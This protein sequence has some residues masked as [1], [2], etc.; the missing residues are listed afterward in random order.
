M[1]VKFDNSR[2]PDSYEVI[3][4]KISKTNEE[5]FSPIQ[6]PSQLVSDQKRLRHL[7]CIH[8]RNLSASTKIFKIDDKK[9]RSAGVA[10]SNLKYVS[11]NIFDSRNAGSNNTQ[12]LCLKCFFTLQEPVDKFTRSNTLF[13]TN[14]SNWRFPKRRLAVKQKI[15]SLDAQTFYISELQDFCSNALWKPIDF[16]KISDDILMRTSRF[17]LR[18]W[19]LNVAKDDKDSSWSTIMKRYADGNPTLILQWDVDLRGL[20]YAGDTLLDSL[21]QLQAQDENNGT[22]KRNE[23][24]V[25]NVFFELDKYHRTAFFTDKNLFKKYKYSSKS[26]GSLLSSAESSEHLNERDSSLNLKNSK[27]RVPYLAYTSPNSIRKSYDRSQIAQFH[28]LQKYLNKIES[29]LLVFRNFSTLETVV[30]SE[31][32]IKSLT[33]SLKENS[34]ADVVCS[35]DLLLKKK[36]LEQRIKW[37][38][39]EIDEETRILTGKLEK[40]RSEKQLRLELLRQRRNLVNTN[41]FSSMTNSKISEINSK[42][43]KRD[44]FLKKFEDQAEKALATLIRQLFDLVYPIEQS[45]VSATDSENQQIL[46][47]IRGLA[48]PNEPLK[49]DY[50]SSTSE[51][52]IATA[53]G[54]TAHLV[55]LL[56]RYLR[57]PLCYP[58]LSRSSRSSLWDFST[59]FSHGQRPLSIGPD[60]GNLFPHSSTLKDLNH[61]EFPL[62]SKQVDSYRY[63]YAIYLLNKNVERLINRFGVKI[64]DIHP[65]LLNLYQIRHEILG[66]YDKLPSNLYLRADN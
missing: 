12:N 17:I 21:S 41:W 9:N 50:V 31:F 22:K 27:M 52:E 6:H 32:S 7:V 28:A 16:S 40:I 66:S 15:H 4:E 38:R 48:I 10:R 64:A 1:S 46:Y 33:K 63:E 2:E 34:P 8:T 36:S 39:A 65:T 47:K 24:Q 53:Y 62:Y 59:Q 11:E 44:L 57:I 42:V 3:S 18:I 20:E 23:P 56:A 58:I 54:F 43:F 29:N 55:V 5:A 51:D 45:L 13:H 61:R 49:S 37:L 60:N 35:A 26:D 14:I 25:P 30:K 19:T